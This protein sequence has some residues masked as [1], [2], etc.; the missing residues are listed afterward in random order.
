LMPGPQQLGHDRRA[1]VP[2]RASHE[3]THGKSSRN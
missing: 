1:D 2:G 3:N